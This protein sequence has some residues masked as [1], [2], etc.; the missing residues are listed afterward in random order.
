M[1]EQQDEQLPVIED[2]RNWLPLPTAHGARFGQI[3][4][5]YRAAS[6]LEWALAR[7]L[8]RCLLVTAADGARSLALPSAWG[9]GGLLGVAVSEDRAFVFDRRTGDEITGVAFRVWGPDF[10]SVPWP[11]A[12][13][14]ELTPPDYVLPP[15]GM[16]ITPQ[17]IIGAIVVRDL[18]RTYPV[19][20]PLDANRGTL[21]KQ[22]KPFWDAACTAHGVNF[23]LP[24]W[25]TFNQYVVKQHDGGQRG[26]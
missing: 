4:N 2:D 8:L 11:A 16:K 15:P 1:D 18:R 24:A 3:G 25:P 10:D 14:D 12:P 23:P 19:G 26:A 17:T 5:A 20:V 21:A 7:R 22:C 9:M 6:D 13:P